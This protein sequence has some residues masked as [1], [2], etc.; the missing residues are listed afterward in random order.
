M[1]SRIHFWLLAAALIIPGLAVSFA[2]TAHAQDEAEPLKI[3]ALV[4]LSGDLSDFGPA[5]LDA[6]QLAAD[7]INE[8]GGVNG[9][10][11]EVVQGD[12]GTSPQQSVEE[13]RRLIEIEG[14]SAIIGPAGS[15]SVLQVAESVTGPAGVVHF[16]A[17]GTSP[18]LSNANDNDFLFRTTIS[19]AAQGV[20]LADVAV[21]NGFTT[22]CV[23]Y[24]NNAYGQGLSESFSN[25]F[26][27]LGGEVLAQVPHEQEQPS[28]S[29]EIAACTEGGPDVMVLPGYPE[30]AGVYLREALESGAI[31]TFLFTDGTRSPQMFEELGWENFDGQFGTAPGA[32]DTEAGP[33]FDQQFEETFGSLPSVPFLRENYD[34]VYLVALAAQAAGS[35]D[36]AAI[37]DELRNISGGGGTV[38]LPGVE[39]WQTAVEL[40][41]NG[42]D[43]DYDGAAG[44]VDLDENGDV[45][46]GSIVIWQVQGEEIVDLETR[47]INLAEQADADAASPEAMDGEEASPEA[48]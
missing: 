27:A 43:I 23:L 14:V 47:A 37:R 28:Y 48:E 31:D 44:P 21:E 46:T 18:A 42:E 45:A 41:A 19:D 7:Q 35:N 6:I 2:A 1:R 25:A 40:L 11:I 20:V 34:A 10:P 8:A 38:I 16:T 3:G 36:P 30:S 39:G 26:T 9:A 13:A 33:I 17:S 4:P 22:A 15:G 29:S 5:F 32:A 24:T 12:S